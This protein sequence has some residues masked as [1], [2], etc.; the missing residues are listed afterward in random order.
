VCGLL[1]IHVFCLSVNWLVDTQAVCTWGFCN[2]VAMS[3]QLQV[4][5]RTVFLP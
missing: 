5:V 2:N 4:F 3:D 1:D